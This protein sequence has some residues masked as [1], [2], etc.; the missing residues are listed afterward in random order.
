MIC[1]VVAATGCFT[2]EVNAMFRGAGRAS[3]V[4]HEMPAR[5][6][7]YMISAVGTL[8]LYFDGI[9]L[10]AG[11]YNRLLQDRSYLTFSAQQQFAQSSPD[12]ILQRWIDD[13]N[14]Q[15]LQ[16]ALRIFRSLAPYLVQSDH[17]GQLSLIPA[18]LPQGMQEPAFG[19]VLPQAPSLTCEYVQCTGDLQWFLHGR[20][21]SSKMLE[22][23]TN[24]S[25]YKNRA[26]RLGDGPEVTEGVIFDNWVAGINRGDQ[27][28]L[29]VL[30]AVAPEYV[31]QV[32]FNERS[33]PHGPNNPPVG[34]GHDEPLPPVLSYFRFK[35]PLPPLGNWGK[36]ARAGTGFLHAAILAN[37]IAELAGDRNMIL[38]AL[39]LNEKLWNN[40]KFKRFLGKQDKSIKKSKSAHAARIM[41]SLVQAL[42]LAGGTELLY[43]K[44]MRPAAARR[45]VMQ[46][47]PRPGVIAAGP[48]PSQGQGGFV[49]AFGGGADEGN[50]PGRV[51]P[52]FGGDSGD[53]DW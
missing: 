48:N 49:G 35:S 13:V 47:T 43:R 51:M 44:W 42:A 53:D 39:K 16:P 21:L 45:D 19:D 34:H 12:V 5:R 8:E 10:P 26:R 25:L 15:K 36:A 1:A 17:A 37:L 2:F 11:S 4:G 3:L 29:A 7:S 9:L 40:E 14:D 27:D 18:T 33:N 38:D 50:S 46:P 20:R 24:N 31:E 23:I 52:L 41:I 28:A 30:H 6:L 32:A 22:R